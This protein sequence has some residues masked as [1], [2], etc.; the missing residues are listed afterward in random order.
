MAFFPEID[1]QQK[2]PNLYGTTKD[3]N[4]QSNPEKEEKAEAI[5][6]AE[7]MLDYRATVIRAAW[8]CRSTDTHIMEQD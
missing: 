4:N 2:S 3:P 1:Q 5:S 8:C 7:F 6:P